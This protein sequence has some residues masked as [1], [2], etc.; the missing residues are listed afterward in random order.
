MS[1]FESPGI[2]ARCYAA[3]R[4]VVLPAWL[5]E[6]AGDELQHTFED[7][8]AACESGW[9]RGAE[10][11]RE[12]AGLVWTGIAARVSRGGG[13]S[14]ASTTAMGA[15]STTI[16][17]WSHDVRFGLRSMRRN[18]VVTVLAVLTLAAGVGA[19][20]AM[21]SVID[22]VLLRPL[23]FDHPEQIVLVNPT[24]VEWRNNPSLHEVWEHGRFSDPEMRAWLAGQQSFAAAGAYVQTSARVASGAGSERVATARSTPGLW[25]ALGAHAALGRLPAAN[26]TDSTVVVTYAFWQSHLGGDTAAVGRPLVVD[27]HAMR[28]VGV[29]PKQF[30]L[31][32]VP[33]D[34]WLPLSISSSE[35][36]NHSLA[37]VARLKPGVSVERAGDEL[38]RI[39]HGVDAVEATHNTHTAH[40]VSPVREATT[41]VRGPLLVLSIAAAVLLVAACASV[42]LLLLGVGADRVG[43]LAVRQALGARR[44]RIVAQLLIESVVLS[45]VGAAAGVVVA[46]GATRMLVAHAPPGV[47]RIEQASVDLHSFAMAALLAIATG[48]VVGCVPAFSLSRVDAGEALRGGATT[49]RTGKLQRGIVAAELA[50][51]T[52]LL[53]AAGLLTRTMVELQRVKLGF[54]PDGVFTLRVQLPMEKFYRRGL[55]YDSSAAALDGYIGRVADA[56][57]AV[58]GVTDV[59]RTSSMPFSSD[60]STNS[61]EPEGYTPAP[62]E[63]VDVA[64]RYVTPNYFSMLRIRP[65]QGRVLSGQDDGADAERVMVVTDEFARHFWPDGRWVGRIVGFRDAKYR[66]VGVIANTREQNLRGDEDTYKFFVPARVG[67]DVNGNFLLRTTV[68]A[69]ALLPAVRERIWGIDPAMAIVSAMAL[70]ERVDRSLAD[71]RYRMTLMSVFSIVAAVFA[72]LGIYGVM[73]RSVARRRREMGL[74]T[75]LGASRGR[76]V[77]MVLVEAC[78]I[79][80]VGAVSGIGL[81]VAGSRL[82]ERMIWGVARV[83][84]ATYGAVGG[85]LLVATVVAAIG[86]ARDAARTDLMRVLRG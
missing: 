42:A 51:A 80:V 82:L 35:L 76:V 16:D 33:A 28:V 86:P 44:Q 13:R 57:R 61:V 32:G 25:S 78:W 18:R 31:V 49:A 36:D 14:A 30:E 1:N 4:W 41:A 9:S 67:G 38:T 60:R 55:S 71:D 83:D 37:A 85:L 81:A 21:Y 84:V 11:S 26:E 12:M 54:E 5:D 8:L 15:R 39:L 10:C 7:R 70:S 68:P 66:V 72:L 27:D 56:L 19:S 53:V 24:I 6:R 74:R 48:L 62:G 2:A 40:I 63:I 43:E 65:L 75:A 45:A 47:P 22:S 3:A 34:L 73:S 77:W 20:T 58:P 59:A 23:P 50:L 69:A 17:Q 64:R 46:I 52:V 79:G 29:L